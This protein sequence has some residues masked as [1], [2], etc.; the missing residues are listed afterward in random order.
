MSQRKHDA[1]RGEPA[2]GVTIGLLVYYHLFTLGGLAIALAQPWMGPRGINALGS[3]AVLT[4]GILVA[5]FNRLLPNQRAR[6]L[7]LYLPTAAVAAAA[8]LLTRGREAGLAL[9]GNLPALALLASSLVVFAFTERHHE[10][11]TGG[12]ASD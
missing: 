12:R 1:P 8:V 11:G 4:T 5:A 6:N 3:L 10:K 2:R 7:L 9:P